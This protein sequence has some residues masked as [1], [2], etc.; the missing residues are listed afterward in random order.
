LHGWLRL[1]PYGSQ[2]TWLWIIQNP[3]KEGY[4]RVLRQIERSLAAANLWLR[5]VLPA[6]APFIGGDDSLPWVAER[7]KALRTRFKY[8][9]DLVTG[10]EFA[11]FF[12][13]GLNDNESNT[14]LDNIIRRSNGSFKQAFRLFYDTYQ[15]TTKRPISRSVGRLQAKDFQE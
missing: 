12:R 10:D 1:R 7:E 4:I 15:N 6:K 5:I 14:A 9:V 11:S 2:R 8:F 13:S 3:P